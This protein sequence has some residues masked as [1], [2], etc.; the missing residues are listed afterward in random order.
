M[1]KIHKNNEL[2]SSSLSHNIFHFYAPSR[3]STPL[4]FAS[5]LS[6][7][8]LPP[9]S[10]CVCLM[11]PFS[12]LTGNRYLGSYNSSHTVVTSGNVIYK[13]WGFTPVYLPYIT[14]R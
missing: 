11:V 2:P 3:F 9:F 7:A 4:R 8:I 13:I 14:A 5:S 12:E 6:S 1:I 10:V